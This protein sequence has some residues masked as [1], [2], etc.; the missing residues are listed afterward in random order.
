M[1]KFLKILLIILLAAL[2]IIQFIPSGR[3]ANQPV[4]GQDIF[5]I[6]EIPAEVGTLLKNACYDCHSQAVKYPWY[7][8]VAPV[9]WLIARDVNIG[10]Q[11]LDFGKWGELSKRK[12]IKALGEIAEEVE[13]GYMPM[14]IYIILHSEA[15]LSIDQR[16]LIVT[17]SEQLAERTLED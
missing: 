10:R 7:S 17:W 16:E 8:Y 15:K 9:S 11:H 4:V 2:V 1:K 14:Q 13:D 5:E 3:P 12:Q 6:V